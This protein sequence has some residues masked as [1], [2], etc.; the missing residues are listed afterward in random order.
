MMRTNPVPDTAT[1]T[2]H[3]SLV[4]QFSGFSASSGLN[5]TRNASSQ[6]AS[7]L[8]VAGFVW[9]W[10]S[11][12]SGPPFSASSSPCWTACLLSTSM[13]ALV[14]AVSGK[15]WIGRTW[16]LTT[17]TLQSLCYERKEGEERPKKKT[18][19]ER[20]YFRVGHTRTQ[21]QQTPLGRDPASYA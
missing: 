20:R 19:R 15:R 7:A 8:A 4:D 14:S 12:T 9:P 1:V 3:F 6:T 10:P 17:A 18:E 13:T 5:L 21:L 2:P 11:C 16:S